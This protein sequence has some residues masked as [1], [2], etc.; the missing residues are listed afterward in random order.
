MTRVIV[1][2]EATGGSMKAVIASLL[3]LLPACHAPAMTLRQV[4]APPTSPYTVT[5]VV[6]SL[7]DDYYS[8]AVSIRNDT[9]NALALAPSMFEMTGP[10]AI[11]L[12]LTRLSFGRKAFRMPAQVAPNRVGN[13]QIFFQMQAAQGKPTEAILHVHLPDGEHQV[14]FDVG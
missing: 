5:A 7:R 6:E 3:L 10:P 9:P 1:A 8:I 2:T 4:V 14:I 12:Q 11:F 13:G